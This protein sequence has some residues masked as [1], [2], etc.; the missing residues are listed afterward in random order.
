MKSRKGIGEGGRWEG[1]WAELL[2]RTFGVDVLTCP[3]C[4]SGKMKMIAFIRRER[5]VKKYLAAIGVDVEG[6]QAATR[7][8]LATGPPARGSGEGG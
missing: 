5:S 2:K 7:L 1:G 6:I 8:A 3:R 4:G